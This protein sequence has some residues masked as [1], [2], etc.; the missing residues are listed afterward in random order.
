MT[1]R[2]AW[3]PDWPT[4]L[5]SSLFSAERNHPWSEITSFSSPSLI[6]KMDAT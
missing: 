3:M 2:S 5:K 1:G 6:E 4:A